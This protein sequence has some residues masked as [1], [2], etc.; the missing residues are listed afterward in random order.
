[1]PLPDDY[2]ASLAS[3]IADLNN[4]PPP[5]QAGAVVAAL[6]LREFTGDRRDRWVHVDMSAPAWIETHDGPLVKGA[7][8]WG[9]R[10]LLRWL[11][12]L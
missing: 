11:G 3:D 5:G 9:V 10:L 6:Y 2:V 7:T 8:G 12:S 4:A 1:M